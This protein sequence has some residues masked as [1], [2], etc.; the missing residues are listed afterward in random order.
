MTAP[1]G[2]ESFTS[3]KSKETEEKHK[4]LAGEVAKEFPELSLKPTI[5]LEEIVGKGNVVY[6]TKANGDPS[7]SKPDGG[8]VYYRSKPVAFLESK[9]QKNTQNAIERV[10]K[11]VVDLL[12]LHVLPTNLFVS[13]YGPGFKKQRKA[14]STGPQIDRLRALG[15]VCLENPTDEEFKAALRSFFAMIEEQQARATAVQD[16]YLSQ[17][18]E[19]LEMRT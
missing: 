14:T 18:Q 7:E 1:K 11:Y 13:T 3:V 16:I 5:S 10:N 17:R 8:V 15:V 2:T 19:R 12:L 9:Y 4:Q 6:G